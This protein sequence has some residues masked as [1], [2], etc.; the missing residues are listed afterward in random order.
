MH[1]LNNWHHHVIYKLTT[2]ECTV[3]RLAVCDILTAGEPLFKECDLL[4]EDGREVC[5]IGLAENGR[6]SAAWIC[7]DKAEMDRGQLTERLI[8]VDAVDRQEGDFFK[9][10][11]QCTLP[12][13]KYSMVNNQFPYFHSIFP[14]NSSE[15]TNF[16]SLKYI[17]KDANYIPKKE[18]SL[19]FHGLGH[20][21][22]L[23][24]PVHVFNHI[25]NSGNFS[26]WSVESD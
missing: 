3:P 19:N 23:S 24:R 4:T 22:L 12:A 13:N 8:G 20:T 18:T 16:F 25:K 9:G 17:Q 5:S 6:L 15:P 1:C 11:F 7:I 21:L 14:R 2:E 26:H 10:C